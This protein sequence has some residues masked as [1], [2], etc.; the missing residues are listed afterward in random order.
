MEKKA[1]PSGDT[2]EAKEPRSTDSRAPRYYQREESEEL[3][4]TRENKEG[5]GTGL[6]AKRKGNKK[7]PRE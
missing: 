6:E 4:Q 1:L 2:E 5:E 3:R 7:T